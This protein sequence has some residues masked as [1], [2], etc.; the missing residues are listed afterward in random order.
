MW[1]DMKALD[2]ETVF[3]SRYGSR[4]NLY[5]PSI[6]ASS[7]VLALTDA[8]NRISQDFKVQPAMRNIVG[9]WLKIYTEY[10]TQQFVIFDKR[11][12]EVVYEAMDFRGLA[13][14]SRNRMAYEIVRLRRIKKRI[15]EYRRAFANLGRLKKRNRHLNSETPGLSD[16]QARIL[17]AIEKSDHKHSLREWNASLKTQ[18]GQR[19]NVIKGL[20]AAETFIPKMEEIFR[21]LG[22]PTELTR[23]PLV[24]SSFNMMAHSKA[25]ARGVWQFMP[26]SG[27]EYM[28]VDPGAGID[29]RL[30]PLKSTVAAARLLK[31]NLSV[32][33]NWPL[34]ITAYNH[35]FTAIKRLKP[36]QRSTALD[37]SLF[38]PCAKKHRL[39]YASSNYYAEFLA[40]LHAEMYKDVFY[41]DSPLPV[42]PPLKFHRVMKRQSA[43]QY[44]LEHGISLHDFQLFNPDI[45]DLK[46]KLPVGLYVAIPG[47]ENEMDDLISA[48]RV[49]PRKVLRASR[50]ARVTMLEKGLKDRRR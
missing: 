7:H 42:A 12:P 16:L 2:L 6:D 47:Q 31:R 50:D 1:S 34:A 19:D 40:L 18:T 21:Q 22:V 4:A 45:R 10:S 13:Q 44:A 26:R 49:K 25:G 11:H 39:G 24:E 23:I 43:F 3:K 38:A 5:E 9:F 30:S 27:R 48:I 8:D 29:E 36:H 14:T 20:L 28:R 32:T 15:S 37:G 33:G 35:G 41:G 17:A 46:R